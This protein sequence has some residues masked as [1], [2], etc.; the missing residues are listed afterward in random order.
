[1]NRKEQLAYGKGLQ[2]DMTC[3]TLHVTKGYVGWRVRIRIPDPKQPFLRPSPLHQESF[4]VKAHGGMD[5]A[6]LVAAKARD[7]LK[8]RRAKIIKKLNA[9]V[10]VRERTKNPV[11]SQEQAVLQSH[12]KEGPN[13]EIKSQGPEVRSYRQKRTQDQGKDHQNRTKYRTKQTLSPRKS[14]TQKLK[15]QKDHGLKEESNQKQKV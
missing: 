8:E 14:E 15:G 2:V 3:I 7:R 10:I 11:D 5:E 4:A 6:L 9:P 13:G 12:A 1:M